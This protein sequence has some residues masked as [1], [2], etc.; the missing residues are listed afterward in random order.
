M[1]N[2]TMRIGINNNVKN[3]NNIYNYNKRIAVRKSEFNA[4][5]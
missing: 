4:T 5:I 1:N 3:N 2:I